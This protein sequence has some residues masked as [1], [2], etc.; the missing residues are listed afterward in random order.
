VFVQN[1]ALRTFLVERGL[2]DATRAVLYVLVE[3]PGPPAVARTS[4]ATGPH[5][6]AVATDFSRAGLPTRAVDRSA[7]GIH[8]IEKLVWLAANGVL[9]QAL[10]V[11]VGQVAELAPEALEELTAELGIVVARAW[12]MDVPLTLLAEG[13]AW[14]DAIPEYRA[15]VKEWAWRNGWI[16]GEARRLGI[17]TPQHDRWLHSA[18]V[19]RL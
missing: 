13:L 1:G 16:Q 15:G 9:C 11:P 17:A 19:T 5:A 10:A 18:G 2:A 14:S 8:E 4:F 6:D 7:F 12:N 3:Q